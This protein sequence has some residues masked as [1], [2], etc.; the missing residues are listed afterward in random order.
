M[1]DRPQHAEDEDETGDV[2]PDE[3][4]AQGD[5]R[6]GAELPHREGDGAERADRGRPHHQ[7]DDAEEHLR[8][9]ADQAR[10]RLAGLAD[11]AQ[12]E[13]AQHGD[14]KHLENVALAERS[15]KGVGDDVEQKAG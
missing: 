5:E 12:R 2:E 7:G 9:S 4:L 1:C 14:I 15:D 3:Q 13:P 6:A 10:E 11:G 8:G